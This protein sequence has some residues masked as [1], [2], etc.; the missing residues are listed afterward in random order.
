MVGRQGFTIIKIEERGKTEVLGVRL[1]VYQKIEKLLAP[2]DGMHGNNEIEHDERRHLEAKK[3]AVGYA[4]PRAFPMEGYEAHVQ[5]TISLDE[6][7]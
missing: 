1:D 6:M 2:F 5:R 7:V 4:M 3:K